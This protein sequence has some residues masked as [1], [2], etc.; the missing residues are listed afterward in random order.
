MCTFCLNEK[1][2]NS[3][4]SVCLTVCTLLIL[5]PPF[6]RIYFLSSS[7]FELF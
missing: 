6:E 3:T 1:S 2:W 7:F 5:L 4:L